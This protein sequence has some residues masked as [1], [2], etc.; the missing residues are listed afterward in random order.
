MSF[1][2]FLK[3]AFGFGQGPSGQ[4]KALARQ[5]RDAENA[6]LKRAADEAFRQRKIQAKNIRSRRRNRGSQGLSVL[7]KTGLTGVQKTRLS[8]KSS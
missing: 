2:S 1:G 6:R 3:K 4:E 8:G 5:R 7:F